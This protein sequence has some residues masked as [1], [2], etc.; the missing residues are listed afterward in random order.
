MSDLL[1]KISDTSVRRVLHDQ[2]LGMH[3]VSAKTIYIVFGQCKR[4]FD[5][6]LGYRLCTICFKFLW[7]R[8]YE[9][10]V[11]G[12]ETMAL[13]Y[14]PLSMESIEWHRKGEAPLKKN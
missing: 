14:N 6:L 7:T 5:K 2:L 12:D 13:Y 9:T 4:V 8:Y 10:I 1:R 11:I 3:K